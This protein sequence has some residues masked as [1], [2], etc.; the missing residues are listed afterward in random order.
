MSV[1]SLVASALLALIAGSAQAQDV[2]Y[3]YDKTADFA[4]LK[5][6]CWVILKGD[7][8]PSDLVDKQIKTAID[9]ELAKK[10]LSKAECNSAAL[11]VGYQAGMSKEKELTSYSSGWGYGPGYYGGWYGGG[12]GF[13]STQTNTI[14][15][16]QLA[17][18]MYAT[19]PH[20]LVWRS[21]ASK[22]LDNEAKPDKQE[23]NLRKA[24]AKMLKDFPP[25]PKDK[26]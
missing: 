18:D 3:N 5:T 14:L 15:V 17:L 23:K 24:V 20:T 16:G 7:P 19:Q 1:R 11:Y 2:R 25:K 6:Y 10:G 26:N 21:M 22:T 9:D 4:K 13:T 12:S 8:P